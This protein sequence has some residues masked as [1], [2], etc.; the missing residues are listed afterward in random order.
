MELIV[1]ALNLAAAIGMLSASIL[2]RRSLLHPHVLFAT[3]LVGLLMSDFAIRGYDLETVGDVPS[4]HI[5]ELQIVLVAICL[6]LWLLTHVLSHPVRRGMRDTFT[7][8]HKVAPSRSFSL[9][10]ILLSLTIILLEWS[11]RLYFS[12]WSLESAALNSIGPRGSAPWLSR[13]NEL[14]NL[15]DQLA[16]LSLTGIVLP[17]PGILLG[18]VFV[19]S[20]VMRLVCIGGWLVVIATLVADGG[21]TPVIA[22][23]GTT[24]LFYVL[25]EKNT[26]RKLVAVAVISGMALAGT[27][28]MYLF[29]AEGLAQLAE[30]S[31]IT[32]QLTY[33][34]DDNYRQT[35]LALDRSLVSNERWDPM[36]FLYVI[37]VNPIPRAI[38]PGKPAL[39]SEYWGNYKNEWTTI[40]FI[41][42]LVAMF[43]FWLGVALSIPIALLVYVAISSYASQLHKPGGV[44]V[45]MLIALY[46]YM[47]L[48][49]LLNIS[50]FIYLPAAA[51]AAIGVLNWI[52]RSPVTRNAH[53]SIPS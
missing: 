35:L 53:G 21:R 52:T 12:D 46:G 26:A 51:I 36:E 8:G 3:I 6:I 29:R 40:T 31:E 28:A 23:L 20:K 17:F 39:L 14:G 32:F 16:V 48:R 11:K 38:W 33:H 13:V 4:E 41:G 50:Q 30:G 27:S 10:A 43:G 7:I 18:Y 45:Y 47:V 49:S 22:V 2:I 5:Y 1:Y 24:A 19:T 25:W 44:V 9:A 34:Q 15:G 37:V 42:E